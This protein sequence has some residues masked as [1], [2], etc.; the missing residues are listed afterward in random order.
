MRPKKKVLKQPSTAAGEPSP[1]EI[2]IKID[3]TDYRIISLLRKNGRASSRELA[4]T[5]GHTEATIRAR[6]RRLDSS[7]IMRVVAMTDFRAAGFPLMAVIGVQI[8]DRSAVDV[9]QDIAKLPQIFNVQIVI[10]TMDIELS[11]GAADSVD[12]AQLIKTLAAIP[13]VH[14]LTPG[15]ALEVI[16]F[17][18]GIVPLL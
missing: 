12:L 10:G 7:G 15:M 16:K 13:G 18:W 5:L 11:A 17:D 9:A 3:T 14:Q 1:P 8:K 6:L 4:Q 2:P